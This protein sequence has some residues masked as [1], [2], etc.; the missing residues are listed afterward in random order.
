MHC[1]PQESKNGYTCNISVQCDDECMEE[2]L[3]LHLARLKLL[4][5]FLKFAI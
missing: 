2:H 5:F 3:I 1:Q 4:N